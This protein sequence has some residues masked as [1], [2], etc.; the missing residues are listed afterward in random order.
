MHT[1]YSILLTRYRDQDA[2][3]RSCALNPEGLKETGKLI[4]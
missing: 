2:V 4:G 3:P 1:S